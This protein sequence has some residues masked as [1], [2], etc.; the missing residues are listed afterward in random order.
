MVQDQHPRSRP[1]V[2]AL[3]GG[4]G[5]AVT[6]Q[7]LRQV[8]DRITAVVGVADD[9]GSSGRLRRDYGILP[10]GDLRMAVAAL[11][12]ND[13]ASRAWADVLQFRFAQGE[14]DGHAIGNLLM[15]ALW[16]SSADAVAGLDE[17]SALVGSVGR[18]LPCSI[19]PLQIVADIRGHDSESP[20]SVVEVTGQVEVATTRGRVERVR[21]E[22]A[23]ARACHQAL[24]AIESA[25]AIVLGPGSW[26][27]SLM[28]HLLL[29]AQRA[30]VANATGRRVLVLNLDP[31]VGETGDF[32][33]AEHIEAIKTHAPGVEFDVVIAD[34]GHM[35]S[36]EALRNLRAACAPWSAQVLEVDVAGIGDRHDQDKLARAFDTVLAG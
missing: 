32:S 19:D 2:V 14:L 18:V 11:C 25:D 21:V 33:P 12:G 20:S 6:L 22:P 23:D 34:R 10:P 16:E 1:S 3:G 15:A 29:P 9:G 36:E 17:L 5:L 4:H 28:P 35:R 13:P 24:A 8:T 7:A 31:Q 26:F 27:T 30:A